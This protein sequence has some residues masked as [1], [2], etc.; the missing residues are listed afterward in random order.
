MK[1][2]EL[3]QSYQ[4]Y[5][6]DLTDHARKL[7]FAG[8]AICWFFK[9]PQVTFPPLIYWALISIVGYFI[10]DVLQSLSGA[11]VT[12]RFTEKKEFELLQQAGT[13]EGD[14]EKPRWLDWPA[15]SF[16]LVKSALLLIGFLFIGGE[17]A[18][19]LAHPSG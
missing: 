13:V 18:W 17:L 9:T 11:L 7:G 6:R 10:A 4:G 14:V 12:K 15:Y 8:A 3:W 5:T 1:I 19:R 2:S 16:F